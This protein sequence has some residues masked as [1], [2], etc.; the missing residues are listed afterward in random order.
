MLKLTNYFSFY[1]FLWFI[2]YKI[3]IIPYNP[4]VIFY[5]I[6]TFVVWMLGYMVYLKFTPKK[7]TIFFTSFI[8]I[9]KVLPIATLKHEYNPTDILFGFYMFI[10]YYIALYYTKNIE[11]IQFYL[12]FIK[13]YQN[14]PEEKIIDQFVKDNLI[15]IRKTSHTT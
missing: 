15:T 3:Y 11:P 5:F 13:Y 4:I 10:V 6:L 9:A 7:L 12:K 1:V 2:F 14:I 8:F